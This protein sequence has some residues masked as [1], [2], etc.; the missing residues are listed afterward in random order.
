MENAMAPQTLTQPLMHSHQSASTPALPGTWK[1]GAGRAI[2]LEPREAGLLRIAHGQLWATYEGP[3][4]MSPD[5][6]GDLV[7][8]CGDQLRI[9]PGERVVVEAWGNKAPAY[10]TWDP[11]PDTVADTS[12]RMAR[13]VVQPLADLRLALVLGAGAAARLA[14]GVAG[15]AVDLVTGKRA[16]RTDFAFKAQSRA[17]RAHGAMS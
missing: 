1:L 11:V 14:A 8:G 7:M 17:W 2:T 13:D 3:H 10:F 5:D 16:A 12:R 15:M 6:S 4:G 9:A